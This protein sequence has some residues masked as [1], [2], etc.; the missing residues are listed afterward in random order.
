MDQDIVIHREVNQRERKRYHKVSLTGGIYQSIQ[1]RLT[2]FKNQFML[3]KKK[4][5]RVIN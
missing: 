3:I 2:S 4:L 5:G 1:N